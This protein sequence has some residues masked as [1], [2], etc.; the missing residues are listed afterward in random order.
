MKTKTTIVLLGVLLLLTIIVDSI[1]KEKNGFLLAIIM[2]LEYFPVIILMLFDQKKIVNVMLIIIFLWIETL[3]IITTVN[4]I[5][6]VVSGNTEISV[7]FDLNINGLYSIIVLGMI[8]ITI[9]DLFGKKQRANFL[10]LLLGILVILI[11]IRLFINNYDGTSIEFSD[12]FGF[13]QT[14]AF[15]GIGAVYLTKPQE[16]E[17][18]LIN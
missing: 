13:I 10:F 18:I 1:L 16:K 5:S 17:E 6:S 11:I 7:I 15:L 12:L 2:I 3:E 14:I 8:I 4:F 9:I